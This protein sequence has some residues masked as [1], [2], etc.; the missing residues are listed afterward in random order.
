MNKRQISA[1][2]TKNRLITTAINLLKEHGFDAIN[3]EDI[4]KAAG[5]AKGT[6]YTHFKKKEDIALEISRTPFKELTDEMELRENKDIIENLTFYFKRFMELVEMYGINTCREWIKGVIDPKNVTED[7]DGEKWQYDVTMLKE[8][9]NKAVV[10]KELSKNTPVELLTHIIIS[11]M[12][13][14]MLCWC[15]SDQKFEP[16]EWTEKFCEFQLKAILKQY[17]TKEDKDKDKK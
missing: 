8:I 10:K 3:V 16:V 7:K 13:G 11:Q 15:F 5:V 4:T 1:N 17:L 14:M 2:E 12:Y 6:F 9:I